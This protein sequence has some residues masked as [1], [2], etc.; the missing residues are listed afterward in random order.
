MLADTVS[1][2]GSSEATGGLAAVRLL[3]YGSREEL[4]R[5][6]YGA[7]EPMVNRTRPAL[8]FGWARRPASSQNREWDW[9][10]RLF[11]HHAWCLLAESGSPHQAVEGAE[12]QLDD[13]LGSVLK[14]CREHLILPGHAP[15]CLPKIGEFVERVA[16]D[17]PSGSMEG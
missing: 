16:T 14:I 8:K 12:R 13:R 7:S 5:G 11:D 3:L 1:P 4:V 17:R 15:P 6:P 9:E 2:L 10:A